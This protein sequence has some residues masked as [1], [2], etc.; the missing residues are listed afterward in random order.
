[1]VIT[2]TQK[3]KFEEELEDD[4]E[5]KDALDTK[6]YN[7]TRKRLKLNDNFS[8]IQ[9]IK[10]RN[11]ETDFEENS[12]EE[13]SIGE[14]F[15]TESNFESK[16]TTSEDEEWVDDE[17]IQ[18]S[19]KEFNF[20]KIISTIIKN[21]IN[22][23]N[24]VTE[25]SS[26]TTSENY[27]QSDSEID[28]LSKQDDEYNQFIKYVKSIYEGDFFERPQAENIKSK[29]KSKYSKEEIKEI[30]KELKNIK[31]I[32]KT[33]SPN[34]IDILKNNTDIHQKQKLLENLYHY[35]NSE[36]LSSDY[37]NHLK[38]LNKNIKGYSDPSLHDLEKKI[39]EASN[40][41]N[42]SDNYREKILLSNMSFDNKI[43]AYK[44]LDV[45]EAFENSDT[46]EYAKYK[47]WIDILLSIPFG[48]FNNIPVNINSSFEDLKKYIKSVRNILDYKLSFLERPKDQI[49]NIVSQMIRNPE[50]N[51]NSIGLYG[52]KGVGKSSIAASIAE[53]LGRPLRTISL[54]GESDGS[55]LTGHGFTYV[56]S[57]P[58][59]IIEI[60]R[61]TKCN[62]PIILFDE[63]DKVSQTHHGKEIIGNLIH[64]TD[65]TTNNKY[66]YDKYFSGLEFDLS[67]ILFIF[68]YNDPSKV[69]KILADRLFK[70]KIDNY[71]LNEKLEIT[72]TH[73]VKTIL[74]K[75]KFT[76]K[77]VIFSNETINYI[78]ETS[79]SDHGMRDIKR[80]FEI[81]VSRINT[82]L[83]TDSDDEIIKLKYKTLYNYYKYD[84]LPIQVLKEHVDIFLKDSITTDQDEKF[85]EP[86]AGMY[87]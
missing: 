83:L 71:S 37:Q 47:N 33:S 34:I 9:I 27:S 85:A 64:L 56:G 62:N 76:D 48:V 11:T 6:V 69:D 73:L 65:S 46:S 39:L 84:K 61:E 10:K 52:I 60:L 51:I 38:I 59:R 82:L 20:S 53:A 87:I 35:N 63:L 15:S 54:G 75:Y 36:L 24:N 21:L 19:N 22:K 23:Y 57:C 45:M 5:S 86:P 41:V 30:N 8:N 74:D 18:Y 50:C 78:V 3:R 79:K 72:K 55:M 80:K 2:R 29:I 43:I 77:E 70:I 16:S 13:T 26:E 12:I 32:Y 67:K 28:N 81:I 14:N 49:I 58:G 7:N 66:N 25:T 31:D 17:N 4:E 1:M 44:R 68:T 42:L 40:N